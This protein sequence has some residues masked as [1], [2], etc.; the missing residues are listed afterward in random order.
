[1]FTIAN[2]FI[3]NKTSLKLITLLF[4]ENLEQFKLIF[5][6]IQHES[7]FPTWKKKKLQQN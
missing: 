4:Q 3:Y 7:C 1:M 5:W 6:I 2:L